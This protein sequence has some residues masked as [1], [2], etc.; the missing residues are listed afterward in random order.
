MEPLPCAAVDLYLC[1]GGRLHAQAFRSFAGNGKR[2]E[3]LVLQYL[4]SNLCTRAC[5]VSACEAHVRTHIIST[6]PHRDESCRLMRVISAWHFFITRS[7]APPHSRKKVAPWRSVWTCSGATMCQTVVL[8]APYC[9]LACGQVGASDV[10]A[11]AI[12]RLTPSDAPPHRRPSLAAY[13]ETQHTQRT[14]NISQDAG[15][16]GEWGET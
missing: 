1:A 5:D 3:I 4:L 15:K 8:S 10:A 7:T 6:D 2:I 13:A 11:S 9:L 16:R 12:V 14:R